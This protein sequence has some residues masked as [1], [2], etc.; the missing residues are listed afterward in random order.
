MGD[1][2]LT[3]LVQPVA[4]AEATDG[5]TCADATGWRL[6]AATALLLL[7]S[8][9]P[10]LAADIPAMVDYPNHLARMSILAR[11]GTAAAH[12]LYEV[13][14]GFHP[15]LAMDL[16]VPP[17]TRFMSV[18]AA[19]RAFLI[20][21]LV[22]VVSGA[23]AL[24]LAHKGRVAIS[25]L[26]AVLFIHSMPFAW[27]FVNFTFALGLALWGLAA[28]AAT[29]ERPLPVRLA[30]HSAL[31]PILYL[32]HMFA[33]GLF[34][35]TV[36]IL[37]L[38]RLRTGRTSLRQAAA[39][40]AAMA[41]PLL[42][43]LALTLL[44]NGAVGGEGNVWGASYKPIWLF[45]IN[46]FSFPA[47]F[48]TTTLLAVG[49]YAAVRQGHARFSGPGAWLAIGFV[50]L[51]AAMPFRLLDTA[52]VDMRVLVAAALILPAFLQVD[53]PPGRW[54]LAAL[55]I[56]ATVASVNLLA[57]AGVQ[58]EYRAEFAR[59]VSSFE[60]LDR[61]ARVL[62]AHAG[63][64]SDPPFDLSAYPIYH[65]PVLAVHYADAFVPTLFTHPGKQP[66]RP[67]ADLADIAL[68]QG[69]TEAMSLLVSIARS[70]P[71]SERRA[72]LERWPDTFRYLY[73]L[74]PPGPN[75]LPERLKVLAAGERFTLYQISR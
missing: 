9:W 52:F 19:T 37:E 10:I 4:R 5:R 67:R 38:W 65:A 1:T 18:E 17:L 58:A 3:S 8:L 42:I 40:G 66:L 45:A 29:A 48:A 49:L 68:T 72:Y 63:E 23:S 71:G 73:V 60:R 11:H 57:V 16:I 44:L 74:G 25:G 32:A 6:N 59:L 13:V 30:L 12:P 61:N 54:R 7:V 28:S 50:A 14:W 27:G 2:G 47:A 69:E 43:L 55:G 21:S 56:V 20:V 41:L 39:L 62:I 51:Y 31:V 36:C 46:G 34:G 22:L 53:L 15:N 70:E 33:L 26:V 24:E 75:P 35:L 64:P